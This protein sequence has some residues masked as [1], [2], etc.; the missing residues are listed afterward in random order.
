MESTYLVSTNFFLNEVFLSVASY[1][2]KIVVI[3]FESVAKVT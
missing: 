1:V 3:I 2:T